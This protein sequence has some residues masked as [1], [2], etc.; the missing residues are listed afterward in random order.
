MRVRPERRPVG[1][2]P[3]PVADE[4]DPPLR[5]VVGAV[6]LTLADHVQV[7]LEHD[8]RRPFAPGRCRHAHD[9]VPRV[10]LLQLVTPREAHSLTCSMT[11]SSAR[12]GRA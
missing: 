11:G 7:P 12:E 5:R 6:G 2:Q 10:V 3:V 8:R 9:E 1:L 4:L